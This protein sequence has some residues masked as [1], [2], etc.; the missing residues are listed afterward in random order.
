MIK[1]RNSI[2]S[3]NSL[4]Q[5]NPTFSD[6]QSKKPAENTTLASSSTINWLKKRYQKKAP[7]KYMFYP[8]EHNYNVILNKIFGVFSC[9]SQKI[10][11]RNL[12]KIFDL[13]NIPLS[14]KDIMEVFFS[15]NQELLVFYSEN[16]ELFS[17][18][19][20]KINEFLSLKEFKERFFSEKSEKIFEKI[21]KKYREMRKSSKNCFLPSSLKE[22]LQFLSYKLK[23]MEIIK[24][25]NENNGTIK[26]KI[27]RI[28][29]L[30]K[31]NIEKKAL[32][33]PKKHFIS[34]LMNWKKQRKPSLPTPLLEYEK[35][36]FSYINN[37]ENFSDDEE[38]SHAENNKNIHKRN[39]N[40]INEFVFDNDDGKEFSVDKNQIRKQII[41]EILCEESNKKLKL[42]SVIE[43]IPLQNI[44]N[45]MKKNNDKN[46]N[47]DG[48]QKNNSKLLSEEKKCR[49][50]RNPL[51]SN[52]IM[53][54]NLKLAKTSREFKVISNIIH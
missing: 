17:K 27:N 34:S 48:I 39:F 1:P 16:N 30:F 36:I 25:I 3:F 23:R 49:T 12:Q 50:S 45:N 28:S 38:N 37:I 9:D 51:V 44:N 31:L 33:S 42:P 15:K 20:A 47:L 13:C 35:S 54:F 46:L 7:T 43:K 2:S 29:S 14:F 21:I 10:S 53:Q 5:L 4:N 22:V 19:N 40:K 24:K 52:K 6:L 18:G 8:Q 32:E 26:E 11:L 41:E